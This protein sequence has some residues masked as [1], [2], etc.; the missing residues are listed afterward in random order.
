MKH[1]KNLI[2]QGKSKQEI[3][4][5]AVEQDWNLRRVTRVL[6]SQPDSEALNKYAKQKAL[7]LAVLQFMVLSKLVFGLMAAE[8]VSVPLLMA[9]LLPALIPLLIIFMIFKNAPNGYLLLMVFA[10]FSVYQSLPYINQLEGIINLLLSA[11]FA[12]FT[13]YLKRRLFPF[14]NLFHSAITSRGH[15]IFQVAEP[16]NIDP[17]KA[18]EHD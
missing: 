9:L 13:Y 18:E 4:D 5:Y 8:Q 16:S 3:Y 11:V 12:G 10:G 6:A 1:I 14:Q 7:L 15:Y 2:A 17:A